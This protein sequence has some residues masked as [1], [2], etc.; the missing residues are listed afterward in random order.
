MPSLQ[1]LMSKPL[2]KLRRTPNDLTQGG[3]TGSQSRI[4]RVVSA[5]TRCRPSK[6]STY[7]R[8]TPALGNLE[9]AGRTHGVTARKRRQEPP[10][11]SKRAQWAPRALSTT[12]TSRSLL[13]FVSWSPLCTHATRCACAPTITGAKCGTVQWNHWL[14]MLSCAAGH[15][16]HGDTTFIAE[17]WQAICRDAGLSAYLKRKA[18]EFPLGEFRRV[19]SIAEA[20]QGISGAPRGDELSSQPHTRVADCGRGR[21]RL[22]REERRELRESEPDELTGCTARPVP[23]AFESQGRWGR[24]AKGELERL[25]RM[26]GGL[27]AGSPIEAANVA[28]ASIARWRRWL[29]VVLR[30]GNAAR[31]LAARWRQPR[32]S[33]DRRGPAPGRKRYSLGSR[34]LADRSARVVSEGFASEPLTFP[35]LNA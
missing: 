34:V 29:S 33:A 20:S 16:C 30:R 14:T 22:A 19:S 8:R 28:T 12:P 5:V 23:L 26:K 27:M 6:P 13:A 3:F 32:A 17:T 15:I 21:S 25:A 11:G 18:A 10:P 24:S 31:V 1:A 2:L 4:Q 35:L 9:Q 7:C